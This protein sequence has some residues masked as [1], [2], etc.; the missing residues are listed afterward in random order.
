[1]FWLRHERTP[2]VDGVVAC[3]RVGGRGPSAPTRHL[4]Y[5]KGLTTL[6]QPLLAGVVQRPNAELPAIGESDG[7][8]P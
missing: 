1:M 6:D 7:V 3:L 4:S 2:L 5:R 8:T